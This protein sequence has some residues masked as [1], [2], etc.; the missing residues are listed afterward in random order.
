VE[1]AWSDITVNRLYLT[2]TASIRERFG[3]DHEL[4]NGEGA[5]LGETCV[6]VTWM[7]LNIFLLAQ[8]G[9]AKYA[10]EI[11]R[12]LYNQ[13]AAAQN[14]RGDDWC[15]Y[16]ALEGAKHYDQGITCCHSSGPRGLALAPTVAYL[17]SPGTVWVNTLETSR[18]QF[19]AGGHAVELRQESQ[20]PAAGRSTLTVRTSGP[21][22]FALQIRV[23]AWA[24]PLRAGEVS[25]PGG[26]LALPERD[27]RD[28]DQVALTF[29][30]S[31]R[32]IPGEFTNYA[33]QA[34]TWGPFVLALDQVHNPEFG[35]IDTPQFVRPLNTQPPTL[36]R[37]SPALVLQATVRGEWDVDAHQ[38]QLVPFADA[39]VDGKPYAVWLRAP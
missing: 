28:G 3:A 21:A 1:N 9:A 17:E 10:D 39:G 4:P 29:N 20:F 32:V 13:L 14:P 16:T 38:V 15:Y 36:V 30:L 31:S 25:S 26:W 34:Y 7:Q 22:R 6:T 24:A 19:A 5:H 27:W 11:E 37:N 35:G 33:R 12:S 8:T 23:P 18:V 2:G